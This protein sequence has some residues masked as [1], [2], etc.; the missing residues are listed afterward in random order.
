MTNLIK[1]SFASDPQPVVTVKFNGQVWKVYGSNGYALN[2][3]KTKAGAVA[4]AK[5]NFPNHQLRVI[6]R[7]A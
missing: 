2:S 3:R 6:E 4:L 1:F 5:R 7:A